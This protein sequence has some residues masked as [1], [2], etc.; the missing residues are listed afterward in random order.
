MSTITFEMKSRLRIQLN[1]TKYP[2]LSSKKKFI[3]KGINILRQYTPRIL[4]YL[5]RQQVMADLKNYQIIIK[6]SEKKGQKKIK[7]NFRLWIQKEKSKRFIWLIIDALVI[8]FTGFL[9]IL[10]GPNFFFY[11]PALL[12]YYHLNSF[13][14]L[15]KIDI[16][17][18]DIRIITVQ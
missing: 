8:R 17:R 5:S 9:A 18:L 10:P 4:K 6:T 14:G 1:L 11:V 3:Q 13:L 15:R 7:H 12:F 2:E 16:D